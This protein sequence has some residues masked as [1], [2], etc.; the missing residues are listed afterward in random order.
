MYFL[1][2]HKTI[3][4]QSQEKQLILFPSNLNEIWGTKAKIAVS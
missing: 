3:N 1:E 4:D 2:E